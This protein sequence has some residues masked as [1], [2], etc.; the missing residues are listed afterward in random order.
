MN[1]PILPRSVLDT[2]AVLD[3]LVFNDTGMA[4]IARAIEGGMVQWIATPLMWQELARVLDYPVLRA[5]HPDNGAIQ[6]KWNLYVHTH[7]AAPP[8]TLACRDADDQQFIDLAVAARA[9]WLVS[10]DKALLALKK[11]ALA[12][13]VRIVRPEQWRL[14]HNDIH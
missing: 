5:R 6:A 8:C 9:R 2:N 12:D 4:A 3:W 1:A 14:E 10:K 13:G 7:A 11:K